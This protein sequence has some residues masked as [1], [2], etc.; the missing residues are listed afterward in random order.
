MQVLSEPQD[1]EV[2][3]NKCCIAAVHTIQHNSPEMMMHHSSSCVRQELKCLLILL[4][5]LVSISYLLC[6][7]LLAILN[8]INS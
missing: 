4:S 1:P 6:S 8:F 3:L 7:I 2:N 5:K